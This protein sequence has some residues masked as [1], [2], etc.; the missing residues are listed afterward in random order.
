MS[1]R[2]TSEICF[3]GSCWGPIRLC[4]MKLWV[5]RLRRLAKTACFLQY[6][7]LRIP[8]THSYC[9]TFPGRFS[10]CLQTYCLQICQ[11]PSEPTSA[12]SFYSSS[13]FAELLSIVQKQR[14]LH[15]L[16]NFPMKKAFRGRQK[17][18]IYVQLCFV[19]AFVFCCFGFFYTFL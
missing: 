2:V 13:L 14:N 16:K 8:C 10:N 1:P 18:Y 15:Q 4:P 5:I 17:Y 9:T 19:V 3:I 7:C 12:I 11:V 6:S